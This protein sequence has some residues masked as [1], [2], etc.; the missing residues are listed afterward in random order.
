[1]WNNPEGIEFATQYYHGD[2]WNSIGFDEC[3]SF[4]D[5]NERFRSAIQS[6][7]SYNL[8]VVRFSRYLVDG[9][10]VIVAVVKFFQAKE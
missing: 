2:K 1:M 3:M 8:R 7:I 5:V 6:N 9:E 4:D 10:K